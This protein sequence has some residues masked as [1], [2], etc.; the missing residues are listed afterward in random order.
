MG[1]ISDDFVEGRCC[2][3]CMA[4]FIDPKKPD[5]IFTH[6]YPVLCNQCWKDAKPDEREGLQKQ[7]PN[8]KTL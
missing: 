1:E 7:L 4:Y 5:E 2:S 8:I 6:A 3:W